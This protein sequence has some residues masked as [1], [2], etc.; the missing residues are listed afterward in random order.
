MQRLIVLFFILTLSATSSAQVFNRQSILAVAGL[1]E[2]VFAS[3]PNDGHT[4]DLADAEEQEL[5]SYAAHTQE[6]RFANLESTFN[7]L[8]D[9]ESY[10]GVLKK[11]MGICRG[12]SSLRRK[13]RIVGF[14][15][16]MNESNQEIPDKKDA[17]KFTKFYKKLVKRIRK[18][19]PTFIPGYNNLFEMSSDPLLSRMLKL[20]V[21]REW[22]KKNFT[23][24]TGTGDMLAGT[25]RRTN[26]EELL[27]LRNRVAEFSKL[28]LNTTMWL[29]VAKSGWIHV[30]EAVDAT[31]VDENGSFDFKFW[32]DKY[33]EL[34]R[35]YSVLT[36]AQNGEM[37]YDDGKTVRT[38]NAAGITDENDGEI[39]YLGEN[40]REFFTSSN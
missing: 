28:G 34:D 35:A 23:K 12:Y 22:R 18:G 1:W 20:E 39:R 17:K 14:F 5:L 10:K 31:D 3:V 2:L 32:N 30:L 40:L 24:G 19:L 38:I 25:L 21:F 29:S 15:D 6:K 27:K 7:F 37:T 36:V 11:D 16:P 4:I 8:N 26:Y 13:F 9:D 33:L